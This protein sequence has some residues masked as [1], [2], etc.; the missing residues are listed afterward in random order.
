LRS[1]VPS[2]LFRFSR[3]RLGTLAVLASGAVLA[4][5]ATRREPA[6]GPPLVPNR[7]LVA[8]FENRT[9]DSTLS[10]LGG[11]AADWIT[12]GIQE[13]A[14]AVAIDP[15]TAF[16]YT[17]GESVA[18]VR[19]VD[20]SRVQALAEETGAGIVVWGAFYR[21]GDSLRFSVHL[22][23]ATRQTAG[24]TVIVSAPLSNHAV[25]VRELR[26]R[27]AGALASWLD[28]QLASLVAVS[29]E[30]PRL[31]A[32]EEY[33]KGLAP[34]QRED[35]EVALQHFTR[36]SEL[37][38]G[39]MLP[40]IW[41]LHSL[42]NSGR[43]AGA[44]SLLGSIMAEDR[45]LAPLDRLALDVES[46][47]Q[48]S[49]S[50]ALEAALRSAAR[51][52][53][54]SNFTFMLADRMD[55][56]RRYEAIR[57]FES[58]DPDHG[59]VRGWQPYY[60]S[61]SYWYHTVGEY[62]KEVPLLRGARRWNSDRFQFMQAEIRAFAA[63]GRIDE[64]QALSDAAIARWKAAGSPDG[65]RVPDPYHTANIIAFAAVELRAHQHV[66]EAER[67][68]RAA[69]ELRPIPALGDASL[70]YAAFI[71]NVDQS[72][73]RVAT[74]LAEPSTWLAQHPADRVNYR[75]FLALRAI[76][77]GDRDAAARIT[78]TLLD[79]LPQEHAGNP[80]RIA[81]TWGSLLLRQAEL[82]A[83]LG[84]HVEAVRLIRVALTREVNGIEVHRVPAFD[85]L[86]DYPPFADLFRPRE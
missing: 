71:M 79:S 28:P 3:L 11:L 56:A 76:H 31:E 86:R 36:A 43:E 23:D 18:P 13:S 52:A 40:R 60:S 74:L 75:Y 65:V 10:A 48:R 22:T 68:I 82:R 66:V 25:G 4:L 49:D 58:I 16:M 6:R 39:F 57:L 80:A 33:I 51:L 7:V 20:A 50:A 21:S 54:K 42:G 2:R 32:Y 72:W 15:A 53:P 46:A 27:V 34:F 24:L 30:P 77:D 63:T 62:E 37:D 17:R 8:A 59:W 78:S 81:S 73:E 69:H 5:W 26:T 61:L 45:R 47:Y 12:M 64:L 38:T 85:S 70:E 1:A 14:L 55:F 29:T 41:A 83:L 35:Y 19:R 9:G 67:M 84:E 44:D